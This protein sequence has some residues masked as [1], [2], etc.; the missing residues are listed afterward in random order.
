[1]TL[2]SASDVTTTA[3]VGAGAAVAAVAHRRPRVSKSNKSM[4]STDNSAL[5]KEGSSA[6]EDIAEV[7]ESVNAISD[8]IPFS[9]STIARGRSI[10]KERFNQVIDEEEGKVKTIKKVRVGTDE[11]GNDTFAYLVFM[12]DATDDMNPESALVGIS[13]VVSEQSLE[14]AVEGNQESFGDGNRYILMEVED[15]TVDEPTLDEPVQSNKDDSQQKESTSVM[16]DRD[17]TEPMQQNQLPPPVPS[18][19]ALTASRAYLMPPLLSSLTLT[20]E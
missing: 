6:Q 9:T 20:T 11:H 10:T 13:K 18:T 5:P 12:A 2:S 4:E 14:K 19:K 7:T 15:L 16:E 3:A 17:A 8:D 1:M